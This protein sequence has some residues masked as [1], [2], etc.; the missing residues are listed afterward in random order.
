[1]VA[2]RR[3]GMN[4]EAEVH[5]SRIESLRIR[6]SRWRA[7]HGGRGR[8][9]PD[10]LWAEAAEVASVEGVE[11]TAR[12]LRLSSDRLE[13]RVAERTERRGDPHEG[14]V[15]GAEFVEVALP[16]AVSTGRAMF[17]FSNRH[18]DELSI[19]DMAGSVDIRELLQDLWGR[20]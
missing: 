13:D 15:G 5:Q 10:S 18:G 7:E 6:L 1:L 16:Q 19:V 12:N 8:R 17:M 9:I 14:D 11:V 3:V 2:Y 4:G 20:R